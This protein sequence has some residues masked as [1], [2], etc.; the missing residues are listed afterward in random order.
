MALLPLLKPPLPPWAWLLKLKEYTD[1]DWEITKCSA[2]LAYQTE[3]IRLWPAPPT[4]IYKL[5][6]GNQGFGTHNRLL[7]KFKHSSHHLRSTHHRRRDFFH[8][9]PHRKFGR[10]HIQMLLHQHF[11]QRFTVTLVQSSGN[12]I[13][14]ARHMRGATSESIGVVEKWTEI[15]LQQSCSIVNIKCWRRQNQPSSWNS[16]FV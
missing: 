3:T 15:G 10:C 9:H 8:L 5:C 13:T 12:L 1:W 6:M 2:L 14:P 16:I 7:Q 4:L 11:V